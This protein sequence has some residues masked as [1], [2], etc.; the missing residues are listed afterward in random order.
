MFHL[1]G[2][3]V[4]NLPAEVLDAA[5]S[6]SQRQQDERLAATLEQQAAPIRQQLFNAQ[7]PDLGQLLSGLNPTPPSVQPQPSYN[8]PT[9]TGTQTSPLPQ[10]AAPVSQSQGFQMPSLNDLLGDLAPKPQQQPPTPSGTPAAMPS[11][12]PRTGNVGSSTI[13]QGDNGPALRPG[14]SVG[15]VTLADTDDDEQ[16]I[17]QAAMRRGINPDMAVRVANTEGGAN[18]G[19]R[20]RQNMQGAPA[21]SHF[22]LYI[23]GPNNPAMG[24]EALAAGIDPRDPKQW[25]QAVD[26]ALDKAKER[27]WQPFQG[28]AAAGIGDW[29]GIRG[30]AAPQAQQQRSGP[31]PEDSPNGG[32]QTAQG[33]FAAGSY[34]PNQINAA[35]EA[36][37]DYETALAVCG[38]AAAIAFAR[39]NGRNPTMQEAV[40]LAREVGWTVERGMAGPASQQRLLQRMG[41]AARLTE[42]T[43]DWNTVAADVQRGNPVTISTPGHYFVAERYDPESGAF[44]FGESAAVLKASKG[45]RWFRPEELAS[46]GMGEARATLFIDNPESPTP[47]I[48][49]DPRQSLNAG[50]GVSPAASAAVTG[51]GALPTSAGPEQAMWS[52]DGPVQQSGAFQAATGRSGGSGVMM[53]APLSPDEYDPRDA[54]SGP[55]ELAP[56]TYNDPD[57]GGTISTLLPAQQPEYVPQIVDGRTAPPTP[58]GE[59]Q[60][61]QTVPN[62]QRPMDPGQF[63]AEDSQS[64]APARVAGMSAPGSPYDVGQAESMEPR[65]DRFETRPGYGQVVATPGEPDYVD[66]SPRT[67]TEAV[68]RTI[69]DASLPG[70]ILEPTGG[71]TRQI[72]RMA[73]IQRM[74]AA[75]TGRSPLTAIDD[76]QWREA[77]PDLADEYD[78]LQ[79]EFGLNVAGNL[80]A[81]SR[82]SG[83]AVQAATPIIREAAEGVASR[84]SGLVDDAV[85]AAGR[86][87]PDAG[88]TPRSRMNMDDIAQRAEEVLGVKPEQVRA[89]QAETMAEPAYTRSVRGSAL[90]QAANIDEDAAMRAIDRLE[91]AQASVRASGDVS[92]LSA[93]QR[94]EAADAALEAAQA[95][96]AMQG[97]KAA[98]T[99]EGRAT[100][101]ALA[102]R[103]QQIVARQGVVSAERA[104]QVGQDAAFAAREV[105]RAAQTGELTPQAESK[106]RILLDK[107]NDPETN[108]LVSDGAGG[109]LAEMEQRAAAV[110]ADG[111]P[112]PA[113]W[114]EL[115]TEAA[116]RRNTPGMRSEA[117]RY[118]PGLGTRAASAVG[119]T[120]V[121]GVAGA[122]VGAELD[123]ENPIRGAATGF[124]AGAGTGLLAARAMRGRGNRTLATFGFSPTPEFPTRS[125]AMGADPTKRYT[126]AY[127]VVDL[128]DLIAS[129]GPNGNPNPAFPQ[130]LQ[131]RDRG[132]VA[133]TQQVDRIARS[134]SPD[135][136]LFD[137]GRLDSGPMIVG[138]DRVVESGNGRTLALQRAADR[139]PEQYQQYIQSL[140]GNLSEYGLDESALRG[141]KRPVLVRERLSDVNR[142]DFAAEANNSGLLRM[143]A[144]EQAA[145]DA[146]NLSDDLV[147]GL[148]VSDGDTIASALRRTDNREQIRAWVGSLPSN[149]QAGVI[150]SAGN[151][152]AQGY[153]RI[154]NALLMRT[155]GEDAGQRLV[156][157][158]VESADPTVRNVQTALLASLPAMARSEAMIRSG[159]R[160]ASL[161]IA[162][163]VAAAVDMLA[164]LRREGVKPSEYLA[165]SAMFERELTP[166][167]ESLLGFLDANNRR[168]S[169]LK[170][171]L[172]Q[173]AERVESTADPSQVSMFGEE[174]S[175]PS[176]EELWQSAVRDIDANAPTNGPLFEADQAAI[177]VRTDGAGLERTTPAT[178]AAPE[179]VSGPTAELSE[180]TTRPAT[181]VAL[182]AHAPRPPHRPI[183]SIAPRGGPEGTL[184]VQ[185]APE[186]PR[187][188][189]R[190]GAPMEAPRTGGPEGRL[191]V[192]GAPV[193]TSRPGPTG[194]LG[195][196]ITGARLR[197]EGGQVPLEATP[198]AGPT[199]GI[200]EAVTDARLAN[201]GQLPLEP[202]A[203]PGAVDSA[204]TGGPDAGL[205]LSSGRTIKDVASQ[206]DDVLKNPNAEGAIQRL[207]ALHQDLQEISAQGF[208]RS[209]EI[210]KRLQRN[211]LLRAGLASKTEDIDGLV[212]ALANTDPSKPEQM[213][214]VLKIISKPRL[215]DHLLEYQ[216]VNM[217]SSPV[218]QGVN[219]LSNAAQTA[220]RLFL[221]NPL[222]H[223][224][225]GG[226]SSGVGAAFQGTARGLREALPEVKQIMRS[227]VSSKSVERAAELGDYSH[228]SRELLTE[229]FGMAGA[230]MHVISTRPLQ[231]MDALFGHMAYAGAAEQYAQRT[232]D[233]LLRSGSSAVKGMSRE[234]ARA[235]V[236]SNIWDY[237]EIIEKAGKISDYT[238]LKSNDAK[239][240]GYGNRAERALRN[241]VALGRAENTDGFTG[242]ASSFLVNQVIPFFN[243]PLNAAKQ[244]VERSLGAGYNTARAAGAARDVRA[245]EKAGDTM[246]AYA[247][248][249][250][251]GELA[252]KATISAAALTAGSMLAFGDNL[253][254]DGPSEPGKRAVWEQT[255]KRNSWRVP[256]TSQWISWEGSPVAIP[257]GMIAGAKEGFSEAREAAAKKGENGTGEA[258][259]AA[260]VKG[261]QGAFSGFASQSFVRALGQ[262]YQLMTGD[263][264]G[265]GTL[266]ASGAG[267]VSRF[268]P[269]SSMVN[270]LALV[271]D[272]MERDAGKP[273]SMGE[274]PENVGARLATRVPGFRQQVDPKLGI[275]GEP[276]PN[277]RAGL[278]AFPYLRGQGAQAGDS[279]TQ[280]LEK[281]GVGAPTVPPD[282]MHPRIPGARIPLA[283]PRERRIFQQSYGQEFRRLLEDA[284][285]GQ[286]D[287]SAA[288]LEKIRGWAREEAVITVLEA[289]GPEEIERR[290]TVGVR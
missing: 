226:Q 25:K 278:G 110:E 276:A 148:T 56:S 289:I 273:Q 224:L 182:R 92:D 174:V 269:S 5:L 243:V 79:M 195:D 125:V 274:L 116:A 198:R 285:A 72:S 162:G 88:P 271:T 54:D 209:S 159:T 115:V 47:S 146:G 144:F 64:Q 205:T 29:D 157:A 117:S 42:G 51:A 107:L 270:F 69:R 189:P 199:G 132:R 99:A 229:K 177:G 111:K 15:S 136:L 268:M 255:H 261:G 171:G 49:A 109:R 242:Q 246:G 108:G 74:A 43:P 286:G 20:A 193:P 86:F 30:Q 181:T 151:L 165:Q 77:N 126:F 288:Q 280:A 250:R 219:I 93:A 147:S 158:F 210:R 203:R 62:P 40:G 1:R 70:G 19:G 102:Q 101:R 38:P 98:S 68:T 175:R 283:N 156:R 196:P 2:R 221:Q 191:E 118:T 16:Y 251:Y 82:V 120:L 253:T 57:A 112:K 287:L 94:L 52:P 194:G 150:D 161:S 228:V 138:P 130:D 100:A 63:L 33:Q 143:S 13:T 214:A 141:V 248:R 154:T 133:S 87:L 164:R 137:A 236:M 122:A 247:H 140:R 284:K 213:Q 67:V 204:P 184:A 12:A 225:T 22:Q 207:Q 24:D 91:A 234:E 183:E 152:S 127:R 201:N 17:R 10:Q 31:M 76:P 176:R 11:N 23:G 170:N 190:P 185:G 9:T 21:Y 35:T 104:K 59:W 139:Y 131:P 279:I 6:Q 134:L 267:T 97:S 208:T 178:P 163:D 254:G 81:P 113:A 249:E 167:Q 282:V 46:L 89:W 32:R 266:A 123:E 48:A 58:G 272:G 240:T 27:G 85:E 277:E 258:L 39:K 121:P 252:A 281:S 28:A 211:G 172:K 245:A 114:T 142:A 37:L 50:A 230:F 260:A 7:V 4:P 202:T 103:R 263:Q 8:D 244:G 73:R 96:T 206:I 80:D 53:R 90:Q 14:E 237:P 262:Q 222:E 124:V 75:A 83:G 71:A 215:I 65:P 129:H 128:D 218:T 241:M 135:A 105:Q 265:L 220:G 186:P 231:A 45:R 259:A 179:S 212:K 145:Q 36:G 95:A 153:E 192:E 41:V 168:P 60:P 166:F 235:H 3:L 232:A 188:M 227:G 216:Y 26:F 18:A 200:G 187:P 169:A 233:R 66:S 84:A 155:Y 44:D 238:L 106:L 197:A 256:G 275:Y 149:E 180:S 173:Y 61:V 55:R 160:D 290:M 119:Q 264:T 257:F 34:T 217:L 78:Q 239:G 223:A